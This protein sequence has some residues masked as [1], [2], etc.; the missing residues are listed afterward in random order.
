MESTPTLQMHG[1]IWKPQRTERPSVPDAKALVETTTK[2]SHEMG[3]AEIVWGPTAE[4]R[5]WR[6][7]TTKHWSWTWLSFSNGLSDG[8]NGGFHAI[9]YD[10]EE[11]RI[12]FITLWNEGSWQRSQVTTK[13]QSYDANND[14]LACFR[15]FMTFLVLKWI[16]TSLCILD[17]WGMSDGWFQAIV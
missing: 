4:R 11:S 3:P 12:V 10:W 2:R 7:E 13:P 1:N 6:T 17:G 16:P 9:G 15:L 5:H 14:F 8:R